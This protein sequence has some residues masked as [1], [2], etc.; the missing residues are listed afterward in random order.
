MLN[1][2]VPNVPRRSGIL[3]MNFTTPTKNVQ[4]FVFGAWAIT[5]SFFAVS[6]GK[7]PEKFRYKMSEPPTCGGGVTRFRGGVYLIHRKR[8]QH[9]N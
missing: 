7:V 6:V 3:F 4:T 1:V 5:D 2:D 8:V 9:Q